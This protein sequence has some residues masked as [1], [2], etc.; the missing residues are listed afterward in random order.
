MRDCIHK[1][2]REISLAVHLVYELLTFMLN[3]AFAHIVGL[4]KKKSPPGNEETLFYHLNTHLVQRMMLLGRSD[5]TKVSRS[6]LSSL[7]FAAI[8]L[9]GYLLLV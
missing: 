7:L 1:R 4:C 5:T 8:L 6:G 2:T 9:R 3:W